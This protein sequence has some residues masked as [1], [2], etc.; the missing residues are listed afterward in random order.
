M[1]QT[2]CFKKGIVALLQDFGSGVA[3]KRGALCV[4]DGDI[5]Y[6]DM[7][8]DLFHQQGIATLYLFETL[9]VALFDQR[10]HLYLTG[11]ICR[12]DL[13][14]EF[15]GDFDGIFELFDGKIFEKVVLIVDG[16][17]T[18]LQLLFDQSVT[19]F[20]QGNVVSLTLQIVHC[21]VFAV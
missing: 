4:A 12:R 6:G 3:V 16:D 14:K 15:G 2:D 13:F 17:E 19:V 5:E 20:G 11:D 10:D 7:G 18:V 1:S 8:N 9:I 21:G